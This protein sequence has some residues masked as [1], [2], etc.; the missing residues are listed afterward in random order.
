ALVVVGA[1]LPLAYG[2]VVLDVA[3]HPL[4]S[5]TEYHILPVNG[6]GLGLKM[7]ENNSCPMYV[8]Y[9]NKQQGLPVVFTPYKFVK[10]IVE[11]ADL[12][13]Q[14][15]AATVC[16]QSTRWRMKFDN[17]L[18]KYFVYAGSASSSSKRDLDYFRILES[19]I[20][21]NVYVLSFC[22]SVCDNCRPVCGLL[23]TYTDKAK[24]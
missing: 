3:E 18:N 17:R 19:E 20:Y 6:G 13:V 9:N 21:G 14:V 7:R 1:I 8:D 4:V 5:G 24:N 11:A 23:G 22:P 12:K 10:P 16:A 15:S 2:D